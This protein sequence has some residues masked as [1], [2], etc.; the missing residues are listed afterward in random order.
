[1]ASDDDQLRLSQELPTGAAFAGYVIEE[2]AGRGGMGVVY[3]AHQLRPSRVVALKVITPLLAQDPSFRERFAHESE[4]AASIEHSNVLPVYEVGEDSELLFIAMRYIEGTDLGKL[5]AAEGRLPAPR[6][7]DILSQLAA[8]L[9]A[10]HARGLVHRDVKPAN[11][12]VAPE[13]GRDHVYLTDFG[14]AKLVDKRGQTRTGMFLGTLDYAAPEQFEGRRVDARTDIYAC[15]CLLFHMLTGRVP[16]TQESEAAIMMAHVSAPIPSARGLIANLAPELDTVI[17]RAM[18]KDP[19]ARYPSAGD[20]ARDAAA[21]AGGLRA[22]GTERTIARGAAAPAGPADE[23]VVAAH[24]AHGQRFS[25]RAAWGL[26]ATVVVVI[27]L[28]VLLVSGAFGGGNSKHS[29]SAAVGTQSVPRPTQPTAPATKT[30]VNNA[31][32]VSFS[33]PASWQRLTLAGTLV[34]L[35]TGGSSATETRCAVVIDRGVAPADNTQEAEFAYVR[36]RSA[37]AARAVKHYEIRS[38]ETQPAANITG[39]GLVRIAGAQGGHLGFFF[40]GRDVYTFDCITP[41]TSLDS[42]DQQAFQPLLASVRI[43]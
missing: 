17:A 12:L 13:S 34:D 27:A 24:A 16:Y 25:S 42:V 37:T 20:L 21:A 8:A 32:G 39:V 19:D 31:A 7:V 2:V 35:G 15:G 43:G 5:I 6:A 4:T 30:Y 1:M 41:A 28:G 23:T 10:A 18:A 40:R 9:D 22:T 26:L 38:I 33:Y 29:T 3:R 36:A 11:V 14:L